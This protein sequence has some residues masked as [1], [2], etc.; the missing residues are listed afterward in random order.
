MLGEWADVPRR[1]L[2]AR[3]QAPRDGVLEVEVAHLVV[4]AAHDKRVAALAVLFARGALRVGVG[5]PDDEHRV[6][7][8][9]R[10]DDEVLGLLREHSNVRP[11]VA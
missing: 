10:D 8:A 2:H 11:C 1:K 9:R 5:L 7:R 4:G 6:A 3:A